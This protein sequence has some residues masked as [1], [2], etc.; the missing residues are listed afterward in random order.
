[1]TSSDT[2]LSRRIGLVFTNENEVI[3]ELRRLHNGHSKVGNWTL[4]QAAWHLNVTTRARMTPGAPTP[5]SPE[6]IAMRP[7][8]DEML[9]SGKMPE[10]L[11]TPPHFTP[12]ANVEGDPIEQLITTLQEF[13]RYTGRLASHRFFGT[14][15]L[16]EGRKLNRIHCAHHLSYFVPTESK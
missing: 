3:A 1:M 9:A 16:D 8:L 7:Q 2:K 15:A 4:E 5:D 6:Q 10:G 12:P 13:S 14:L 11:S